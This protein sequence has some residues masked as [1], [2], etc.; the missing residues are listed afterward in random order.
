MWLVFIRV[1]NCSE[2]STSTMYQPSGPSP[3]PVTGSRLKSI[4]VQRRPWDDSRFPEWASALRVAD[5][6]A[7]ASTQI[8]GFVAALIRPPVSIACG[9]A[10]ATLAGLTDRTERAVRPLPH[11]L[12]RCPGHPKRNLGSQPSTGSSKR[13]SSVA[14]AT[15]NVAM[16]QVR[17]ASAH[18]PTPSPTGMA[19]TAERPPT[20]DS[21]ERRRAVRS[22][23]SRA[24]KEKRPNDESGRGDHC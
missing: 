12:D 7:L 23:D 4:W 22:H 17:V 20:D 19:R 21:R 6:A 18:A 9:D 15:V 14:R 10:L 11:G 8:G 3:P 13:R 1:G 5:R 16:T 2:K 24:P